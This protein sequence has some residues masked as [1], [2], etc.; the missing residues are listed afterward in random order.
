MADGKN[1]GENAGGL[2]RRS[3]RIMRRFSINEISAVDRPAQVGAKALLMKRDGE[4][5]GDFEKRMRLTTAVNG[6][7]HMVQ[8]CEDVQSGN[9]SYERVPGL[10]NSWEGHS[11]PWVRD[12]DGNIQI[13]EAMGHVHEVIYS[14]STVKKSDDKV[15]KA[16]SAAKEESTEMDEKQIA[17]LKA[18]LAKAL[19]MAAMNDAEKAYHAT[20]DTAAQDAFLAKSADDRRAVVADI[21]KRST[22]ANPVVYTATDG[23]EFRKNDDPRLVKMAKQSDDDRL[24]LAKSR[25]Q[26]NDASYTK[27]ATEELAHCPGTV[28]VRAALLKALD[29]IVD[30]DVRA[31][32][33]EVLKAKD[34]GLK[35]AFQ[36]VGTTAVKKDG[37]EAADEASPEDKIDV[38][39]KA[40][41]TAKGVSFAKAYAAV[42]ETEEGRELYSASVAAAVGTATETGESAA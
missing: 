40:Y 8:D 30:A 1:A 25:E 21:A 37:S 18:S 9:T 16:A 7:Q 27:R 39:A 36:V 3:R 26:L 12:E 10:P 34:A 2:R 14:A 19:A 17:E 13:G 22:E 38:L 15:D 23:S 20:L 32:A 24:L 41:A 4:T 6:H 31:A 5:D 28:P 42:I 11:H 33:L 35:K 29:T